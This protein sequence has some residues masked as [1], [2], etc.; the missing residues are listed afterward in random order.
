MYKLPV[1]ADV[2]LGRGRPSRPVPSMR[3][4]PVRSRNCARMRCQCCGVSGLDLPTL[5]GAE[6]LNW[7]GDLGGLGR[8]SSFRTLR[9][10]ESWVEVPRALGIACASEGR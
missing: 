2:T 10:G 8:Y 3:G 9:N 5:G 1:D 7:G 4:P 6:V